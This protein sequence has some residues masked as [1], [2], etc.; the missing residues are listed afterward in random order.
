MASQ[1]RKDKAHHGLE[2]VGLSHIVPPLEESE[3]ERLSHH[4]SDMLAGG[5]GATSEG[6]GH[7]P[8]EPPSGSRLAFQKG[9][10]GGHQN[11][12]I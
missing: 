12:M 2:H 11:R 4:L 1:L 9:A 10:G 8:L 3:D 7:G 6:E 5:M